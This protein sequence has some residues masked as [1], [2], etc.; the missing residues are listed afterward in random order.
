MNQDSIYNHPVK[1][2]E[3][4]SPYAV[5]EPIV[6]Y[7]EI[8]D[9]FGIEYTKA[10]KYLIVGSLTWVQGWILDLTATKQKI[11]D[12]LDCVLPCLLASQIPFKL[13]RNAE[14]AS[15]TLLGE[16]GYVKHAKI[17]SVY[18]CDNRLAREVAIRLINLTASFKGPEIL[19]DRHLGGLVYTRYGACNPIIR[20]TQNGTPEKCIYSHEGVLIKEPISI[21]FSLPPGVDWPFDGISSPR[22]PKRETTL[23]DRYRPMFTL[24]E[25][26]KGT[27]R[28]GLRL[29]SIYKINW[30]VLKEG[31]Y[32]MLDDQWGRDVSD[33]LNWQFQLQK[34]LAGHIPLPKVY[35]LFQENDNTYLVMEFLKGRSLLSIVL[36]TFKGKPLSAHSLKDRILVL[37]IA[38]QLLNII[39]IMHARG[40]IHRDITPANFLVDR[41]QQLWMIDLEL[42]Y[43]L[44]L[45]Y[46]TPPFALGS[47]G[48][49]SPE[50][51]K[52]ETPTVEQD[53]YAIGAT[54]FFM[55]TGLS[56]QALN[57][58]NLEVLH[59]QLEY[60]IPDDQL[61]NILAAC[62]SREPNHRPDVASLK[63]TINDF[64]DKQANAAPPIKNQAEK[65]HIDK[66]KLEESI[67]YAIIGLSGS[68]LLSR[69]NLWF[70]K[71]IEENE[72][73]Y[74]QSMSTSV[75]SGFYQG[76]SGVLYV[77]SKARQSA[78]SIDHCISACKAGVKF[79][80]D[81]SHN[82]LIEGPAGLYNG[83]VGI[84]LAL[85]ESIKSDWAQRDRHIMSD[86]AH[87]LS[88]ENLDGCSV[89]KGLAGKGLVLLVAE[90]TLPEFERSRLQNIVSR[91]LES[92]QK[93]GSWI[94][95]TD[96]T[97][98]KIKA[99]GFAY[100]VSGIICFF[101]LYLKVYPNDQVMQ[102]LARS[103]RWLIG[104]SIQRKGQLFWYVNNRDKQVDW[105]SL[106]GIPGVILALIKAY[107]AIG[108]PLYKETANKLLSSLPENPILQDLT[109]GTGLSGLGELYLEAAKVFHSE[110][111]EIR[112]Q[113]IA[114][115][116]LHYSMKQKNGSLIWQVDGT[117]VTTAEL[118]RGNA[119]IL[120][121]LIRVLNIN[122]LTHPFLPS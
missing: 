50:Q 28:K 88:N 95:E 11:V 22:P 62:L 73:A 21:P 13:V 3:S 93:D 80:R 68:A 122:S 74:C 57:T 70:S 120:H 105:G 97:K 36:D 99:T 119:G 103:V 55:F 71:T 117:P 107:E 64:R 37:N 8:L 46:P 96:N 48:Y 49:M 44:M 72:L 1:L 20:L 115:F 33:R 25:D 114:Q 31:R 60:F 59:D 69:E 30:C 92:Q 104:Q 38:D 26:T 29:E 56:P 78:S 111:W 14:V 86:I 2:H 58:H 121:F 109:L 116:I 85:L 94:T 4:S 15:A 91:I 90:N 65:F 87:C 16:F 101:A 110:E 89:A 118:I 81:N 79:I 45:K 5:S 76:I 53:V 10:G 66:S 23:Q 7:S 67:K 35:D 18:T 61:A 77:L 108:D 98:Q 6:N 9:K 43:S 75:Y 112:A 42:C 24:K 34:D 19:T 47:P 12:I 54:L 106:Q 102:A 83:T 52:T 17:L 100:G 40:Y 39:D 63:S 82:Q 51:E 113:K 27:V 84:A 32:S 41:R